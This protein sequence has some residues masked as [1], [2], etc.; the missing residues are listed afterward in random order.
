MLFQPLVAGMN[1]SRSHVKKHARM[2]VGCDRLYLPLPIAVVD[3]NVDDTRDLLRQISSHFT[4]RILYV[5]DNAIPGWSCVNPGILRNGTL[6]T[7]TEYDLVV[8]GSTHWLTLTKLARVLRHIGAPVLFLRSV[9][10]KYFY[11]QTVVTSY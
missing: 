10:S 7:S 4:C 3:G 6:D 5:G 8:V 11:A 9:D 1:I 2:P